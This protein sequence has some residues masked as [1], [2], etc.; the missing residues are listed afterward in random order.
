MR[1]PSGCCRRSD[2]TV[3]ARKY[4]EGP[5]RASPLAA[6][7]YLTLALGLA[8]AEATPYLVV[9]GADGRELVRISLAED[10]L[11]HLAWRHSVTGILVRDFYAWRDG[12]L[13]LTGSHTPAY[14]AGLGHIPGRGRTRSDGSG[15]YWILDIDEPVPGDA[16]WLRVGPAAVA[17]TI[18]HG[19]RRVNL[20]TL[21]AGSRVRI[22]VERR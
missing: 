11:W 14:D 4:R 2:L 6:L 17:H 15:G 3:T 12:R 21:A 13:V 5:F 16:Y 20:S 22:A 10:P 18:V 1:S 8:R 7:L 19:S 9:T